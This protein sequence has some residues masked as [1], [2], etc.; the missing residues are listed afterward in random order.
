MASNKENPV[1]QQFPHREARI[2]AL[3]MSDKEFA[4]VCNDYAE[5]I[6]EIDKQKGV[7]GDPAKALL[8]LTHLK[9][10][11]EK[12]IRDRLKQKPD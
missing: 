12:D 5:I 3:I 2:R 4:E 8:D 11:L 1:F 7:L 9:L 6:A 10:D